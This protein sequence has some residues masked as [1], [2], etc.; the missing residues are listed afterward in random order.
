MSTFQF[1]IQTLLKNQSAMSQLKKHRVGLIAHP[2]SVDHQLNHSLYLLHQEGLKI[3]CAFGPQHGMLGEKQDNMIETDDYLDPVLKIPVFSLYGQF[4]K[5]TSEMLNH[6]DLVLF[7]LQDIGTRVYTFLTTLKL[8]MEA[9]AEAGKEL[10]ILDR[11]NPAGRAIEGLS[12][13]PGQESFVGA[14][15]MPMRHGLTLGEAALYFKELFDLNLSLRIFQMDHYTPSKGPLFGWPEGMPWINPSPNAGTLNMVRCFP[16]TVMLEGTHLSEMRGT[17]RALEGFGAPDLDAD[18]ILKRMKELKSEWLEG[19]LIRK[20][21]FEPTFNKYKGSLCQGL[22]FHTDFQGYDPSHFKP[23][24]LQSLAFKAIRELMP[25]YPLWRDFPYEY[26]RDRLAIDVING[27]PLLR[28]WVDDSSAN[29]QTFEMELLED[30]SAW[31]EESRD[32]HLY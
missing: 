17:T 8:V 14:A 27:G 16:G 29:V 11:P 30:E 18:L 3:T 28:E 22:Q 7:D 10:W 19:C 31:T 21:F 4:R 6:C 20:V 25:Q 26:E 32:Y 1:G 15:P 24:R 2:A 9:C 5:P 23:Y 12:L 13:R